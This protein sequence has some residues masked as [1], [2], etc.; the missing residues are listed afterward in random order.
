MYVL[1]R[2]MG[3]KLARRSLF[4]ALTAIAAFGIGN[5][6]QANSICGAGRTRRFGVSPWITGAVMTVLTAV[7][8][9]G[10]I[11]SIASVC[12]KL[13]PFMAVF[14]VAGLPHPARDAR[15]S[16]PGHARPDRLERVHRAG[17]G[18][19]LPRRRR[20][21]RRCATASRAGCS[22]TSRA[23]AA[24]RSSPRPRRPRTRCAR[25]SSRRPA[26]SGTPSSCARMTGLVVVQLGRVDAGP[27]RRGADQGG[28]RGPADD[29]PDRAHR[30]PADVRVLDHPR[31]G[32]LRREGGRV[33]VRH[34]A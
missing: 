12:E 24:R 31:L 6:V 9:L 1:E 3:S 2:G 28:V 32:L 8:I 14:Y 16:R 33:P 30:R 4:A 20:H 21:A 25:R 13:V 22:P 10:G 23:W 15:R 34:R 17:R 18:R 19:R 29:R 27:E 7:V 5:M 11:K 26:R